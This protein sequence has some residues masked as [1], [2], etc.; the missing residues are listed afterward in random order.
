MNIV[1]IYKLLGPGLLYAAA[2][3]GV[4][5]LVQSTRAGAQFGYEL[6]WLVLL[7]NFLK[8]PFYLIS[9][10]Y[11][12][13]TGKS[14]LHGY[15]E[16]GNWAIILFFL[17]TLGTMFT[18][19]SAVT[20]VTAGLAINLFAIDISAPYMSLIILSICGSILF[21]GKVHFLNRI[22]K[23]III[24]LTISTILSIVISFGAKFPKQ[25]PHLDF[26]IKEKGHLLFFL[27]L[28]GWMPAPMDVP[29]W[30]SLWQLAEN[31]KKSLKETL[32]DF[33][34]GY[35]GTAV[36]AVLFLA[37]GSIVLYRSGTVLST[38]AV[39]FSSQLIGLYTNILGPS[40]YYLIATAAFATMFSTSLTCLDAFPR[41]LAEAQSISF[42]NDKKSY[43]GKWLLIT[44]F[45][46]SFL[47]LKFTSSMKTLVDF[48]TILS[49]LVTPIYAFLNYK[50]MN[51]KIMKEKC[52]TPLWIQILSIFSIGFFV[53]FSLTYVYTVFI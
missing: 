4:S 13:V 44:I 26:S 5:H 9:P 27:A 30:Q 50:I 23:I 16:I 10:K 29:I 2:A 7:A 40:S 22:V 36:L 19:Q 37:L 32:L 43:Y 42:P 51:F 28:V 14:L 46:S 25:G 33:H 11:T 41:I 38:S 34:I 49:F 1:S 18:V 52:P 39:G 24:I 47:L 20:L 15:K 45:G 21:W 3:I 35:I 6:I 8:Y 12:S 17:M 31:K 48:A 53:L